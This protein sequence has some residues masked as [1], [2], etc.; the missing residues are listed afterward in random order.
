VIT[1]TE[2]EQVPGAEQSDVQRLEVRDGVVAEVA[3]AGH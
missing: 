2:P 3:T 1:A